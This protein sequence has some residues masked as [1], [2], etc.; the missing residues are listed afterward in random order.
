M[1][2]YLDPKKT[3]HGGIAVTLFRFL[4]TLSF[5]F[6]FN[7]FSLGGNMKTERYIS[8]NEFKKPMA[9]EGLENRTDYS[10]V[11][12]SG[13]VGFCFLTPMKMIE[14]RIGSNRS[15][16]AREYYSMLESLVS[17]TYSS[18][19]RLKRRRPKRRS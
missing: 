17:E 1:S 9:C 3:S 10:K 8:E 19:S 15:L 11:A 6:W 7:F 12:Y 18:G 13:S 4:F 14:D 16:S 5:L 2:I